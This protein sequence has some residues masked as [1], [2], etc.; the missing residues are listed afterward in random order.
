MPERLSIEEIE[1]EIR[2]A[3]S[4]FPFIQ[5]TKTLLKTACTIK[6]RLNVSEECYIQIYR[7][8]QKNLAGYV[9]VLGC[10]RIYGRD[11]DGGLWHRHREDDPSS[12]D[13]SH[14]GK[15]EV[16]IDEFLSETQE[17]LIEKGIL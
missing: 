1:R 14:E 5:D 13:F 8:I 2:K 4:R 9:A 16:A 12:H 17:I 7:N 15:R 11:C 6:I 3:A 10:E